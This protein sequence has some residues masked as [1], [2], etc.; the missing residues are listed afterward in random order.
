[1]FKVKLGLLVVYLLLLES[2][3]ISSTTAFRVRK[4]R[5]V[6]KTKVDLILGGGLSG[7]TAAK[8]LLDNNI[9]DFY[10]LEGQDYIGGRIHAAQFEGVTIEEGANWLH[11]LDEELSA[12]FLKWK[13]HKSMEGIWCNYSDFI[14]RLVHC[15]VLVAVIID[16]SASLN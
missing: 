12:R 4:D 5:N 11:S 3:L 10:V 1:M 7:I 2:A 9:K 16:A 8:T 14:I 6:T 15:F 13:T